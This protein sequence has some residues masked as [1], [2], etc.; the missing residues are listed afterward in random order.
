MDQTS[1]WNYC[2]AGLRGRQT[3]YSLTDGN[4]TFYVRGEDAHRNAGS[5]AK[6]KFNVGMWI[7]LLV[8]IILCRVCQGEVNLMSA[9]IYCPVNLTTCRET[10]RVVKDSL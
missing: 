8:L 9:R 1:S 4:H 6:R 10:L 5:P 2:G 3:F 7:A